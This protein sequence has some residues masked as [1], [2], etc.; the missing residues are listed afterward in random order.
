MS[1]N[2]NI[3]LGIILDAKQYLPL[4]GNL[5]IQCEQ[6]GEANNQK[7]T[8]SFKMSSNISMILIFVFF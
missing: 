4:Y 6:G 8:N 5:D 2:Y 7:Q 1:V 3:S